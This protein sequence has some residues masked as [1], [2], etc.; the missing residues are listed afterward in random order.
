M[1]NLAQKL[2]FSSQNSPFCAACTS[3]LALATIVVCKEKIRF[4][5]S[6]LFLCVVFRVYFSSARC[7]VYRYNQ[8]QNRK[9]TFV[10]IGRNA[11]LCNRKDKHIYSQYKYRKE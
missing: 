2:P 8:W 4:R 3:R 10:G 1:H 11:Y 6:E 7:A 5:P 9:K